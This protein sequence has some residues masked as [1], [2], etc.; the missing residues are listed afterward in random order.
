[1]EHKKKWIVVLVI[2][3]LFVVAATAA[4]SHSGI[5]TVDGVSVS[6]QE[7]DFQGGDL[8]H[9]IRSKVLLNWAVEAGIAEGFSEG[10]FREA[11]QQ[12][13]ARRK[14]TQEAGAPLYGPAQFTPIQ[15][16]KKQLGDYTQKLKEEIKQQASLS[17][18]RE[19]YES[20]PEAYREVD[21][22]CADYTVWQD[23]RIVKQG[24]ITLDAQNIRALAE[25]DEVLVQYLL[26]MEAGG[27]MNW[28]DADGRERQLQC[29]KREPGRILPYEEVT[30]AVLEHYA[31]EQFEQRLQQ[32]V[33]R[34]KITGLQA[35]R[36][37]K[38]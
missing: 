35:K 32:R 23:D 21:T 6:Q 3:L 12:E 19:F 29:V 9:V 20:H 15:Y 24:S 38:R 8:E 27:Q 10:R 26:Q 34:A 22:I 7:I 16:Y 31:A 28:R 30:G 2:G 33:E 13:N 18:Q 1:M 14:K 37:E 17:Q 25:T 5:L 11:L 4:R 36:G